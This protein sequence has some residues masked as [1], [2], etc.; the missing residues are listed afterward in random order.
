MLGIEDDDSEN[1][2]VTKPQILADDDLYKITITGLLRSVELLE[3]FVLHC[4]DFSSLST[5]RERDFLNRVKE[6]KNTRNNPIGVYLRPDDQ[7]PCG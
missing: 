7:P 4:V 6:R 1:T 3:D 5:E 2:T